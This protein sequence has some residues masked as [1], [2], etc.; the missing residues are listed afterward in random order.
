MNIRRATFT[1]LPAIL[2]IYERARAYMREQGNPTQWDGGYP[3]E[4]LLIDD[5]NQKQLYV[6]EESGQ[7]LAVFCYFYG[8]DPTYLNIYEG[9]WL[10]QA[11]YGVLHRIAVDAKGRG[12][13]AFCFDYCLSQC[14]NLKIDTHRDNLPMQKTLAKNGFSYCGIIYLQSGD[15]R[16]AYQKSML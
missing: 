12:V 7:I 11:P 1:E 14:K 8:N 13:A 15:D 10:N 9:Q 2:A 3:Q 16:L 5:I 4:E 6:C